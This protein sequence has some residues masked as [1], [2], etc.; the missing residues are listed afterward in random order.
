[1]HLIRGLII[2]FILFGPIGLS[3]QNRHVDQR[4]DE[5]TNVIL[6]YTPENKLLQK[7]QGVYRFLQL[8]M[9]GFIFRLE[10][11]PD[12]SDIQVLYPG[13]TSTVLS[14]VFQEIHRYVF[15][16]DLRLLT[17]F[18]DY[19]FETTV[20]NDY[21]QS[22]SIHNRIWQGDADVEWPTLGSLLQKDIYLI[23][24]DIKGGASHSVIKNLWDYAAE[25]YFK[26]GIAPKLNGQYFRGNA[27]NKLLY[28]T[29]FEF[30]DQ[31]KQVLLQ[32]IP[33]NINTNPF[34]LQYSLNVWKNLG[35]Q[36]NFLICKDYQN[37]Y[38]S[39]RNMLHSHLNITG[40]VS[41]DRRPL[42]KVFWK[43]SDGAVTYGEYS[44][45]AT[46]N[47]DVFL[48]PQMAGYRFVPDKVTLTK[49]NKDAVQNFIAIPMDLHEN[50]VAYFPFNEN[51]SDHGPNK[52]PIENNGS[53]IVVDRQRNEV[54]EFDGNSFVTLPEADVLGMSNSDFTVSVWMKLSPHD[55][56]YDNSI[57]GT[58][59]TYY[60][61]GLHLVIRRDKPYFGFYANDL[62]GTTELESNRWY[63][64]VWR[65]TKYNE[66][67]TI[68]VNGK[69]SGA[70]S[71]HPAFV[72]VE[73]IFIGKCIGRKNY[74][75]GFIDDL[76]IWD[77]ALGENEIWNIYQ[78]IHYKE[79][80][81]FYNFL[82]RNKIGFGLAGLLVFLLL[83]SLMIRRIMAKPKMVK[84]GFSDLALEEKELSKN[85]IVL[86]GNF[87]VIDKYGVDI[88]ER[89]TPRLRQ[90][91]I[92]LIVYSSES[93]KGVLSDDFLN[94]IWPSF[95]RKKAINNRGVSMSKLRHLL[96][97]MDGV[98]VSVHRD[99]W[100]VDMD[101]RVYCD[102]CWY[103]QL[104]H[105][106]L[107]RVG[108]DLKG[109]LKV[110]Q[111]G[112]F[113]QDSTYKWLDESK[114]KVTNEVIDVLIRLLT[115][116]DTK[117][118]PDLVRQIAD[119]ILIVDDVNEEAIKHKIN[120]LRELHQLNKAKFLFKS[121][122]E[123]YLATY[124]EAYPHR[125]ESLID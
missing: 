100:R 107:D 97:M 12:S 39:A 33:S 82:R 6:N 93:S 22:H 52:H 88:T 48:Q 15:E 78:D 19:D 49:I 66:E 44:F 73:N 3:G 87:L 62:T 92:L 57:L 105:E 14:N 109:F 120:A 84:K 70:S 55:I 74:L 25:P 43:D 121:F 1:M 9:D 2:F 17:L 60:R 95:D 11:N 124:Q 71:N 37:S 53:K 85:A 122:K 89:F 36:P 83:I 28:L 40:T 23:C 111:R 91:L 18:F 75:I 27:S 104:H 119:R 20:L 45:P 42:S 118:N 10:L 68:F 26:F 112:A 79:D 54:A 116:F 4:Y 106:A 123:R 101:D 80:A 108:D 64:V 16:E 65:Y 63:H 114:G 90:I 86:F 81:R 58:D 47:E 103:L 72:S 32:G 46:L 56:S 76:I 125:F 69:L 13:D 113:L 7:P 24:F 31:D 94:L 8:G 35:K 77:R 117:K 30:V 96:E 99:V 59:G 34:Y 5:L 50:L 29:S 115:E 51:H 110:V 67:Q 41:Y 38:T 98:S 61:G 102:Y 21:I